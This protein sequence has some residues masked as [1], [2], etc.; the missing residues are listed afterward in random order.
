MYL[1]TIMAAFLLGGIMAILV[2]T[3]LMYPNHPPP[4]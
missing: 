1:I 4:R 2:R 3:E